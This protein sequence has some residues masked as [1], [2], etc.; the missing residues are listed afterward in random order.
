M[1]ILCES[2]II[3]KDC[4]F[5]HHINLKPLQANQQSK[6]STLF[7]AQRTTNTN[8]TKI[9]NFKQTVWKIELNKTM[10]KTFVQ[11]CN[12]CH[13]HFLQRHLNRLVHMLCAIH[14]WFPLELCVETWKSNELKG[15]TIM[16]SMLHSQTIQFQFH[17]PFI[18]AHSAHSVMH[19][20]YIRH[21]VCKYYEL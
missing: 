16:A 1:K 8:I 18:A 14:F 10:W 19:T 4:R 2:T 5:I 12:I 11:Q 9:F 15:Y 7:Y 21:I 17:F 6:F 3:S 20:L 13:F